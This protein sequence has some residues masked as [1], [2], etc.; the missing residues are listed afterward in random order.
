FKATPRNHGAVLSWNSAGTGVEYML[1]VNGGTP[2][3]VT[4]PHTVTGLANAKVHRFTLTARNAA[5]SST[6]QA[7]TQADLA[8]PRKVFRNQY[9]N[10]TNTIIRSHPTGAG[11]A[12]RIPQGE[13]IDVTVICQVRGDSVTEEESGRTSD[14]WNRVET[15][16]ANGYLSDT[17]VTTTKGAFPS[18]GLY[19]CEM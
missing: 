4:S 11:Q 2:K 18:N 3:A 9:N 5:G 15:K 10:Q 17:L 1:S 13:Y 12:G 8:Y 19:E 16:Y 14:I 7:T 6:G